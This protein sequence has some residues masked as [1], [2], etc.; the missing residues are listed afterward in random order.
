[1]FFK[2]LENCYNDSDET[3]FYLSLNTMSGFEG[4]KEM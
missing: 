1:M 3:D 4:T 2:A